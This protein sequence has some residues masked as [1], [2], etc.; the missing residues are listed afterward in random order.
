MWLQY[1]DQRNDTVN[2][3][4]CQ[5]SEHRFALTHRAEDAIQRIERKQTWKDILSMKKNVYISLPII[6]QSIV[7]TKKKDT[8]N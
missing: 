7:E 6:G 4:A 8:N 5:T 2:F 1:S 3:R